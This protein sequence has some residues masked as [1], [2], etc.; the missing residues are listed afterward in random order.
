MYIGHYAIALGAKK[1]APKVS[2]GTLFLAAIIIDLLMSVLLLL[3]IEHLRIAPGITVM[4]PL[5]LY[6]YPFSHS[7]LMSLLWSVFFAAVYYFIR[8][9]LKD[10]L[11]LGAIV[12][13][14]WILDLITHIADLP[15]FPGS[16][17]KVGLGIWNNP[18]AS[19]ITE[20]GLFI[21]G[22]FIYLHSTKAKDKKGIIAFWLLMAFLLFTWIASMFSPPPPDA[23]TLAIGNQFQWLV[24]LIA[25]LINK[26]REMLTAN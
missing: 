22:V 15:L 7:L 10:S 6:D 21:A 19:I 26:R 2:L 12:F 1:I 8:H 14:H 4:T 24:I 20:G 5:D 23:I 11:V 17:I 13:S 18:L 3:G 25:Y 16:S 9:S